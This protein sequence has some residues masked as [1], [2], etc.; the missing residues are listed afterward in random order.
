MQNTTR[1]VNRGTAILG[2]IA[3]VALLLSYAPLEFLRPKMVAFEPLTPSEEEMFSFLGV[4][5]LLT[6][7]FCLLAI[8][9]LV[10]YIWTSQRLSLFHLI[11]IAGG[12]FAPLF[13]LA[14]IALISDIGRQYQL[15]LAQ[16]EWTMLYLVVGAQFIA[17]ACLLYAV[18]F[19]MGGSERTPIVTRDG[20]L[21]LIVHYVGAL[22]GMLGF[23]FVLVNFLY[24]RPAWT[25]QKVFSA[26]H[27]SHC[28]AVHIDGCALDGGNASKRWLVG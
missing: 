23:T 25:I 20:S 24:P 3:A 13:I 21:F 27:H 4:A 9:L 26:N 6:L 15:G 12:V 8:A 17:I 18:V 16:P 2:I 22:C 5:L 28:G 19:T 1:F 10:R 11:A 14:D 7:A